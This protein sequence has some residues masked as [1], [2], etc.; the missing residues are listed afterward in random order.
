MERS[1]VGGSAS[2]GPSR[3]IVPDHFDFTATL[4]VDEHVGDGSVRDSRSDASYVSV[5]GA[6]VKA[7]G[8]GFGSGPLFSPSDL[9]GEEP[10]F[11]TSG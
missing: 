10:A 11:Q 5:K 3:A 9:A 7:G 4:F 2:A 1:E 6:H 8:V